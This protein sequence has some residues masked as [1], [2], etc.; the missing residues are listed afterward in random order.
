MWKLGL[1][2][3]IQKTKIMASDPITSWQIDGEIVETVTEFIL[4]GSKVTADSDCSREIKRCLLLGG[5]IMPKLDSILKSRDITLATKVLIVKAM[6]FLVIMYGCENWTLKKAEPWRID[7]FELWCWRRTESSLDCKEIQPI[8]PKG[9]QSWIFIG[10]TDAEAEIPILWPPDAKN[11]LIGKD[12]EARKDWW[13]EEK[14]MTE[15]EMV[16]WHHQLNGHEF[17]WAPGDGDAQG[18]LVCYSPWGHKAL[19]MTERLNWTELNWTS[20]SQRRSHNQKKT[21]CE[22]I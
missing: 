16:G 18:S 3:N 17:E 9:N 21:T 11:W 10:R 14:G 15:D 6:V 7:A 13:Q 20:D 5:K 4:G 19:D 2:I 8:H 22:L 12:P 1:K